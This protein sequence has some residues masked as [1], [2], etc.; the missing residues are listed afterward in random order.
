MK[1]EGRFA[2]V[3]GNIDFCGILGMKILTLNEFRK[4]QSKNIFFG[5]CT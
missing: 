1:R 5:N 3:I 2:E 4:I